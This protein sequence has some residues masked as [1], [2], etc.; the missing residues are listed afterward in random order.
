L[1]GIIRHNLRNEILGMV[2]D[3]RVF[4]YL[5]REGGREGGRAG[6]RKR[7]D[8]P[9]VRRRRYVYILTPSV[10]FWEVRKE[11]GREGWREGGTAYLV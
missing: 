7:R 9:R 4:Q 10:R 5:G 11:G 2:D 8:K 3:L 1:Q 6:G